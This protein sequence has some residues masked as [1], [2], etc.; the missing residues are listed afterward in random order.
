[1]SYEDYQSEIGNVFLPLLM[2]P[3]VAKIA[4]VNGNDSNGY[5]LTYFLKMDVSVISN[6]SNDNSSPR[7]VIVSDDVE[8]TSDDP[9][10]IVLQE[11]EF[12]DHVLDY[13]KTTYNNATID[14]SDAF[15]TFV[16]FICCRMNLMIK[17]KILKI[18]K[19]VFSVMAFCLHFQYSFP[20]MLY[21]D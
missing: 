17:M 20:F 3:V 4:G 14:D 19:L 9:N 13:T 15:N 1:M 11:T 21:I 6:G 18:L 16:F 5:V 8:F 10:V 7:Y 2:Y 12:S